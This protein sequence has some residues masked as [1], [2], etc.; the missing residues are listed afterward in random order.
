MTN[1]IDKINGIRN[2]TMFKIVYKTDMHVRAAYKKEGVK[3]VKV[4]SV[5][6]RTGVDYEHISYVVKAKAN[7]EISD[8]TC[9]NNYS[10]I[11][12]NKIAYNSNTG[13]T[14]LRI[15]PVNNRTSKSYYIV[16]KN[17][18]SEKVENLDDD[19]MAMMTKMSNHA[20]P[21]K[22]IKLDNILSL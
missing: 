22:M 17:G 8:S 2:G 10:W 20:A 6:T 9:A 14:Y 19:T 16:T 5:V 4:T 7:G 12:P 1:I 21:V 3:I 11:V 13:C 18:I 15:A